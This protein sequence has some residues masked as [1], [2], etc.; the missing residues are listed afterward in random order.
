MTLLILQVFDMLMKERSTYY[1]TVVLNGIF[2][3]IFTRRIM[4][5]LA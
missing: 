1:G 3:E 4:L 2:I 5:I